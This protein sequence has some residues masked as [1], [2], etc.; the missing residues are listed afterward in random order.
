M[1]ADSGP[2][3]SIGSQ[4]AG[5][6]FQSAGDQVIHHGEGTLSAG[7]L[8]AMSEIRSALAA[9]GPALSPGDREQAEDSLDAIEAEMHGPEPNKA[10]I[11]SRLA[12]VA[13]TL[14][15]AGTL[16]SSAEALRQIAAWLGPAGLAVLH[17][18]L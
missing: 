10:R 11:A 1:T 6:I 18:L 17:L 12:Q 13:N 16:A 3:F 9:V 7:V 4:Q 2:A 5:A 14:K 8:T 15:Q